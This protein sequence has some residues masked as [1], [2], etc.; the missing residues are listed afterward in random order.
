MTVLSRVLVLIAIAAATALPQRH[1]TYVADPFHCI[2]IKD[3]QGNPIDTICVPG[4]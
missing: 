1:T 2:V 3:G 4:L